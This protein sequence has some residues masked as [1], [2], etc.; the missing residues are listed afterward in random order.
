MPYRTSSET[1]KILC[2]VHGYEVQ[3]S[4]PHI[5]HKIVGHERGQARSVVSIDI[6]DEGENQLEMSGDHS[7]VGKG[8]SEQQE[9]WRA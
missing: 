2:L 8:G 9:M 5:A 4:R 7:G 6:P 1:A 3:G